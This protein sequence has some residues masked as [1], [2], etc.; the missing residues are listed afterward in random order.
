MRK[1]L[2]WT[3]ALFVVIAGVFGAVTLFATNSDLLE[4]K[5]QITQKIEVVDNKVDRSDLRWQMNLVQE[6]IWKMDDRYGEGCMECNA[7][8]KDKYRRLKKRLKDIEREL[9]LI[10][11]DG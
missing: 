6:Q 10:P 5:E 2:E 11:K 1:Y 9:E 8:A 4:A 7:E 3:A